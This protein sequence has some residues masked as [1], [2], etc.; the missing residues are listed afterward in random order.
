MTVAEPNKKVKAKLGV[1]R[2]CGQYI[3]K[4]KLTPGW[5]PWWHVSSGSYKCNERLV[6]S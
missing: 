3:R 6:E 2:H 1:C 5:T 4:S